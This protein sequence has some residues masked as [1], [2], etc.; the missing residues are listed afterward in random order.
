MSNISILLL[1]NS[2]YLLSQSINLFF[3]FIGALHKD[4]L[5][6]FRSDFYKDEK[7]I[8]SQN[9]CSR[10]DPF[11]ICLSRKMLEE[12]QHIFSHKVNL[13]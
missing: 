3:Y 11:E 2:K 5:E 6:Q 4:I 9:V 12:T 13:E 8:L 7:N 10:G 1:L